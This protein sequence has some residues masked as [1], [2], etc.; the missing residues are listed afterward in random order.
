MA[1]TFRGRTLGSLLRDH[2]QMFDQLRE[3]GQR[4]SYSFAFADG[5]RTIPMKW[6]ADA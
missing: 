6:L 3:A 5:D 1:E 4:L 2:D